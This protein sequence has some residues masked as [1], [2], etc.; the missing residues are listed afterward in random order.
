M[1]DWLHPGPIR[2]GGVF[3]LVKE[4]VAQLC[5]TLHDSMCYTLTGSCVHGILQARILEW[6]FPSQG[7]FP[8]KG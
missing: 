6:E 4:K 8:N 3:S 2:D 1:P 7:I 5:P